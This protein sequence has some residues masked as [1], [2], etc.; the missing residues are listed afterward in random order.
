M[1]KKLRQLPTITFLLLGQ[2][3]HGQSSAGF[4]VI[5]KSKA[6]CDNKVNAIIGTN[7]YCL[8][9]NPVIPQTDF[10]QVSD[11]IYDKA[12]QIK[13]VDLK[14]SQEGLKI[15]KTLA[16]KLPDTHLALVIEGKV[17]GIFEI[18]K[19]VNE[20]VPITGVSP[21]IDWIHDKIKKSKQ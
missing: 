7:T 4:Y 19:Q 11:V 6:G 21:H 14:L 5:M 17:A 13:Y 10:D 2:L 9:K 20:I 16:G 8:P 3:A 1:I 18:P 12:R 15:L